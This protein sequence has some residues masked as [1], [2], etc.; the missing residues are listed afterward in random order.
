[1]SHTVCATKTWDLKNIFHHPSN[2]KV[3]AVSATLH[4]FFSFHRWN[5]IELLTRKWLFRSI[6]KGAQ[7]PGRGITT[8][9]Q[10]YKLSYHWRRNYEVIWAPLTQLQVVQNESSRTCVQD[11]ETY[12]WGPKVVLVINTCFV[13][14]S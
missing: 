3:Q 8:L 4:F 6:K 2:F 14:N 9:V 5:H 7:D 12:S 10:F 11:D 13:G 1:M